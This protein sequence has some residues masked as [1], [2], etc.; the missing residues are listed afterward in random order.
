MPGYIVARAMMYFTLDR[1]EDEVVLTISQQ[2]LS[3]PLVELW[4]YILAMVLHG[5][6]ATLILIIIQLLQ[7]R[8]K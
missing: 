6:T 5:I 1:V 2:G 7:Y 3:H 8:T 4:P